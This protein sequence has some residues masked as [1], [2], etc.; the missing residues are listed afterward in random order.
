MR[1][2]DWSSDVCSSDLALADQAFVALACLGTCL[3][4]LARRTQESVGA[5]V[6]GS[7]A[8]LGGAQGETRI[9]LRLTGITCSLGELL[10]AAGVRLLLGSLLGGDE[11]RLQVSEAGKVLLQSGRAHV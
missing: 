6:Q 3:A 5:A 2:S 9:H 11:P 4:L 1:I 10:T 7:G 8:L